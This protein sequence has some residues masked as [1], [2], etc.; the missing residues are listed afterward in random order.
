[1]LVYRLAG[2]LENEHL[3]AA[4]WEA[5]ADGLE[6]RQ[7]FLRAYFEERLPLQDD[8][9]LVG[10]EWLIEPD[11]DWQAD[12]KLGLKPVQAGRVTV[13]PSWLADEVPD[14]QI[15]LIIEPGMAFGTGH[16]A[17]TR[18]A[19]EALSALDLR[20]KTV[21][22]VGT[23]SGVLAIAATLLG[24]EAAL[25]LDIDPLTLPVAF[26]NAEL[27]GFVSA[28]VGLKHPNGGKLDFAEGTLGGED[29]DESERYGA[30]VANLYAELH[31]LLAADYRE[32]LRAGAP[33]ILTGILEGKLPLVRE[34]LE[35]EGF[36]GVQERLDGE[37]ALVT[38]FNGQ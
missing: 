30:L 34:A 6:E 16:H 36:T 7:G 1:M 13:V 38:A 25:G 20:E 27:N 31:D 18:M 12:W 10:G 17:T 11:R 5:G 22:D 24:A 37:W 19:V 9:Q 33:L 15:R 35:R 21:L 32:A 23:G 3:T 4:L 29:Y 28:K 2:T 26:E 14:G 8:P